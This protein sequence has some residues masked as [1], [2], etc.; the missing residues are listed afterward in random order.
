MGEKLGGKQLDLTGLP[1]H[2]EADPV[3]LQAARAVSSWEL[4]YPDWADKLIRAYL[5][6]ELARRELAIERGDDD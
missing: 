1:P 6:P 4:G 3:G 2:K 5:N